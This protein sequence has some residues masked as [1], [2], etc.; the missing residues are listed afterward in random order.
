MAGSTPVAAERRRAH[1]SKPEPGS[2]GQRFW[3]LLWLTSRMEFRLRYHGSILGYAWSMLNPLLLFAVLYVFF[4]EVIRFG[5]DVPHYA[6]ILLFGVMLFGFFTEG[7][8]ACVGS[9]VNRE[10][11][12]RTTQFPRIVIPISTVST[13]ALSLLV[14]LP[15]AFGFL[16]LNGV[17]PMWTWLWTPVLLALLFTVTLSLGLVLS[18]LYVTVRDIAP[19]WAVT[20]RAL[21]YA[22]PVVYVIDRVP[23][24]F[25]DF[26][27]AN[28]L[29]PILT[30]VRH[31]LIDPNA[32]SAWEAGG[33]LGFLPAIGVLMVLVA[34]GT[35]LFTTRASRIAEML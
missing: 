17:N 24:S 33:S 3:S 14:G 13:S 15:I 19:I 2:E 4:S 5:A 7:T 11:M 31:W 18:T 6:V 30:Q 10:R 32:P 35:Y 23:E 16:L 29:A 12:L 8:N 26:V 1:L 22:T 34:L 9:L 28:P 21:F 20:A 27:Y 25:R